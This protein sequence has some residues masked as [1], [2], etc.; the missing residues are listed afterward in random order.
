VSKEPTP[1]P[2]RSSAS[3]AFAFF[4][5]R[6]STVSVICARISIWPGL[7]G[8]SGACAA[9]CI[10]SRAYIGRPIRCSSIRAIGPSVAPAPSA[11]ARARPIA[12]STAI[13]S[14]SRSTFCRSLT[15]HRRP[16]IDVAP[17]APA[18][19]MTRLS[20]S[21]SSTRTSI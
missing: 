20:R 1:R 6:I 14:A 7:T 13:L 16:A 18:A 19:S 9:S 12:S 5:Y 15:S 4:E 11:R 17:L 8:V 10:D 2:Q 3:S 21:R